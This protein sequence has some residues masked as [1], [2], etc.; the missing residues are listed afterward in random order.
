MG[1]SRARDASSIMDLKVAL[2]IFAKTAWVCFW[3]VGSAKAWTKSGDKA[4]ISGLP[5]KAPISLST[6][7]VAVRI[8]ARTSRA[9][10]ANL[11]TMAGRQLANCSVVVPSIC[12]RAGNRTWMHP[13]FTFHFLSSIPASSG[14]ITR[15]ATE[16]P[17][18]AICSTI[19]VAALSA[20]A[21]NLLLSKRG[22]SCGSLGS[23]KG[24]AAA[25]ISRVLMAVA[26]FSA[27]SFPLAANAS[28]ISLKVASSTLASTFGAALVSSFFLP[29]ASAFL[30][31][32][33]PFNAARSASF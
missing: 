11:E 3:L 12:F 27:A 33:F 32:A 31:A 7:P 30:S 14:G 24:V 13:A 20:G 16:C 4:L 21:A 1:N 19:A 18:G 5:T 17:W 10:S 29:L 6:A 22:M 28:S 2:P 26:F 8:S 23:T 25:S 9:A 15:S